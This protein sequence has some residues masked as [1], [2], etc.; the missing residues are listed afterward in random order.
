MNVVNELDRNRT[1]ISLS[2]ENYEKYLPEFE[3]M[4]KSFRFVGSAS[5]EPDGNLTNTPTNFSGANLTEF[6]TKGTS[7]GNSPQELYDEC[8]RVAG[9]NFCDFLFRK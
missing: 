2:K 7:N 9:K 8:F 5:S 4:V 6:N 1:T 3:Q